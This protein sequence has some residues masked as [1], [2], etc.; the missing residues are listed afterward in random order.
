MRERENDINNERE[1]ERERKI[2][3]DILKII[4][5]KY[6]QIVLICWRLEL[7]NYLSRHLHWFCISET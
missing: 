5:A 4:L 6:I 3:T 7:F 1:R 2:V